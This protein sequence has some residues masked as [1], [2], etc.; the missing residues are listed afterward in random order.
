MSMLSAFSGAAFAYL[1][2][3]RTKLLGEA[4]FARNKACREAAK[5]CAIERELDAS[6]HGLNL[7]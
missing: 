2:A 7:I 1:R 4:A 5:G 6:R 3:E